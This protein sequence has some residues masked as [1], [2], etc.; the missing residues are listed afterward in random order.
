METGEVSQ[1][2]VKNDKFQEGS[3]KNLLKIEKINENSLIFTN[4]INR[5]LFCS[6]L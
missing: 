3:L 1:I 5:Y 2:E 4:Q 6:I